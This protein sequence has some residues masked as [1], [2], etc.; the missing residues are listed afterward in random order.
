MKN[1]TRTNI[2]PNVTC[3]IGPPASGKSSL[4]KDL[5]NKGYIHLNRDKAGGA[6]IDL[7]PQF[8]TALDVGQ[9]VVLDNLFA[10][11]LSRASF[12]IAAKSRNIPVHCRWMGTS[13]EDSII[14]A[15][16]RMWSR[17]GKLFLCPNDFKGV[18]DP[19]MFPIV[20]F[21]KYKKEF[22]KPTTAEGFASVNKPRMK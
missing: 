19:N 2:V 17:Y 7:L 6:V 15:L 1:Y 11:Q 14:N 21:F 13:I 18:K 3:I 12:L 5:S 8:E 22:E 10:T 4:A 16:H 20:V 9:N